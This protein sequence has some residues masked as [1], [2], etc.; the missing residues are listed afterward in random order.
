MDMRGMYGSPRV[1]VEYPN[2]P[3]PSFGKMLLGGLA[4]GAAVLW[5]RHQSDQ[6]EKL[7]ASAGMPYES[8]GSSLSTRT[9]QLSSAAHRNFQLLADRFRSRKEEV[10]GV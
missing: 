8:F 1:G 9:R 2:C 7:Y 3:G 10:T 6:V 5:A 4:V